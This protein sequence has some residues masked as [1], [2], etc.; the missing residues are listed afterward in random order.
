MKN[1]EFVSIGQYSDRGVKD[2][3]QDSYG[4]LVPDEPALGY[5]G[6]VAVLA[7]GVS[8][9]DAGKVASESCVKSLLDDYYCTPDSWTVKKSV[10]KVLL[11][12]NRW[13]YGQGQQGADPRK[14]LATTLSALVVKSSTGHIFHIGDTRIYRLRGNELVQLTH[15]HRV[16]VSEDKNYLTRAM[17]IDLRLDI[18]Y[19]KVAIEPADVFILTTDGVH[20]Y[21]S[22]AKISEFV[23]QY[24]DNLDKA[25]REIATLALSNGSSDNVSCQIL[26]VDR[27][28]NI[29]ED[30][31]YKKLTELPFPPELQAGMKIDGY[32]ILR[33]LHASHRTQ[34]YLAED[35]DSGEQVV[36]KTPSINFE[37]DPVFLD[38]FM[39][40][41]W[42]GTRLD[43]N[44]VLR[45]LGQNRPRNFLYYV[46]EY[47]DG[48]TLRGWMHD[49]PEPDLGEVR[50]IVDQISRGLMAFHNKE[51]IHQDLK[52]E[53][54]M[55][56]RE[57]T[58]KI[59]DFGSTKIAGI[60][61]ITTPLDRLT[62]LG[63]KNYTA[64]EYL[65]GYLCSAR[66]DIF[67][68]GV[69]VYEMITGQLPYGDRYNEGSIQRVAYRSARQQL[70]AFPVWIDR[71]LEKAVHKNAERRYGELSEFIY[72]L[73]NPN[74][75]FLRERN[76]PLLARNPLVFWK[77]FAIVG[78]VINGLLVIKLFL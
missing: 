17:G 72:D 1:S 42:V 44:H 64:P 26:R 58:V 14:G 56:D 41:E 52:P 3:N 76:E 49:N 32:K 38:M 47:I 5:K 37:D 11:A 74:N 16:W 29:D 30:A 70:P 4:V 59:I 54:I 25:A 28:P 22:D 21:L 39:H 77:S 66:S 43:N 55:I 7:D 78:L 20:E 34:V 31:L 35:D 6:I 68:L 19:Q 63:T 36:L 18:D 69:I 53:N 48:Q 24:P 15:D 67:S 60:G 45:V 23:T 13:M 8:G 46:S 27:L 10:K 71:A 57:G 33:E 65:Q 2:E 73:A 40:E 61:E 9:C 12:T 51:M 75:E 62:L 50:E